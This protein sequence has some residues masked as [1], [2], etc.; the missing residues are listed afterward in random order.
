MKRLFNK[1]IILV[2]L[3]MVVVWSL[4]EV[5]SSN[6]PLPEGFGTV[7]RGD[8][9]QRVSLSGLLQPVR[10]ALIVAP[11]S[12][13]VKK[14]FVKMGDQVKAGDPIV[15]VVQ[16]LSGFEV[17]FPL[18]SPISGK[19]VQIRR[20]EGEYV[21]SGEASDFIVRVDDLSEMFVSV[22]AAEMDRMK[23]TLHQEAI[24]KPMALDQKSYKAEVV[25][26]ALAANEKDRWDRS[27]VVEYPVKMRVLNPDED[28]KSG[29]S[30]LIDIVIFRKDQLLTLRH[31]YIYTE[32]EESYVIL[33][34]GEKRPIK[35]GVANEE[36]VEILEGLKEGDKVQKVD[37]A[38]MLRNS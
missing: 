18:R 32:G 27:S 35:T 1:K 31:E 26:L 15:S 28:L 36:K 23:M 6:P 13:Y 3:L 30:T 8:I 22:N 33:A 16:S 20:S 19:V 29:M 7:E 11:Y 24:L 25:E 10:K 21:R 14:I 4:R 17:N 12:G 9:I 5:F 34:N 37:F 38:S 2:I